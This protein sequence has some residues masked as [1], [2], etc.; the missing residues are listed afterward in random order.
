MMMDID[1]S[2]F[3]DVDD[4]SDLFDKIPLASAAER[5]SY[6]VAKETE[7]LYQLHAEVQ[8]NK[9]GVSSAAIRGDLPQP[10]PGSDDLFNLG[11][12]WWRMTG[13]WDNVDKSIRNK[14]S[15]EFIGAV[16]L[17]QNLIPV[18]NT[19]ARE[20]RKQNA[21]KKA[22][23]AAA[24]A[25]AATAA[26]STPASAAPKRE[27]PFDVVN[28]TESLFKVAERTIVTTTAAPG[29]I[30]LLFCKLAEIWWEET[31]GPKQVDQRIMRGYPT[32]F[33]GKL[34]MFKHQQD[35]KEYRA[36][37]T[38][39]DPS[40]KATKVYNVEEETQALFEKAKVRFPNA[41][42]GMDDKCPSFQLAME[43]GCQLLYWC[44]MTG[45]WD[46]INGSIRQRYP[47]WFVDYAAEI[48]AKLPATKL[49][50][51]EG[52]ANRVVIK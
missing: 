36:P 30:E 48:N 5:A 2:I 50:A 11:Y 15:N 3:G 39:P 24:A 27:G 25:T 17:V 22:R 8:R 26:S 7:I 33:I 20:A 37:A 1:P 10:L 9:V 40:S 32:W 13:G 47:K 4:D 41:P 34:E 45:G 51:F 31:G 44:E 29:E 43:F 19:L 35:A 14:Y 16:N 23:D 52:W 6:D 21:A 38:G 18:F 28:A 46:N 12:K 49:E 42:Q